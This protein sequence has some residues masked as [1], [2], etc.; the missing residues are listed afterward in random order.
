METYSRVCRFAFICN[1]ISRCSAPACCHGV[2]CACVGLVTATRAR[3]IID[4]LASRCAKF[5][6]KP[7]S[8]EAV[9][10]RLRHI[11]HAEGSTISEEV[12]GHP[13]RA[14]VRAAAA[15]AHAHPRV[16]L[17]AVTTLRKIS[18]GDLRKAINVLQSGHQ[19][20]G[21]DL[22][23]ERIADA[24]GTLPPS[25][26]APF[27]AAVRARRFDGVRAAVEELRAGGY[28]I[29]GVLDRVRAPPPRS[30]ACG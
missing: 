7:L 4:P 29:G 10:A 24:A 3:R 16:A 25:A 6:F 1:Y 14:G 23:P 28:G 27:W 5:R 2:S 9:E 22:T 20:Y 13:C 19:L 30:A 12:R 21:S 15:A 18:G 17:Q 26:T 8:D 11:V